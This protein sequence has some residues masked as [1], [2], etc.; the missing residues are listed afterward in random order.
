MSIRIAIQDSD[1]LHSGTTCSGDILGTITVGSNSFF[2]INGK[3]IMVDN[4]TLEVPTHA[5]P[6]CISPVIESHSYTPNVIQ[7]SVFKINGKRICLVGDNYSSDATEISSSG[8]N[9]FVNISV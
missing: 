3:F 5:N 2:K 7:Q 8:S 9:N 4:G 1:S 6:P